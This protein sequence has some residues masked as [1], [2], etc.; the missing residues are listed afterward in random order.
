M[1]T[2]QELENL[3]LHHANRHR[4]SG[5]DPA[6]Q[7]GGIYSGLSADRPTAPTKVTLYFATDTF[8]LS[9]WTGSAW[10]SVTL[11]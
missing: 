4:Q 7:V 8:A 10:K 2:Q 3:V 11:S 5:E 6:F 9:V 1:L